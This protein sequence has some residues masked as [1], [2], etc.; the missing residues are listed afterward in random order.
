MQLRLFQSTNTI[1]YEA[2]FTVVFLHPTVIEWPRQSRQMLSVSICFAACQWGRVQSVWWPPIIWG[3]CC[4][5][6]SKKLNLSGP[7]WTRTT[8][9]PQLFHSLENKFRLLPVKWYYIT[10]YIMQMH[11]FIALILFIRYHFFPLNWFPLMSLGWWS[12]LTCYLAKWKW[13]MSVTFWMI[14][15]LHA[16]CAPSNKCS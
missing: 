13:G 16:D 4:V 14:L 5:F 3:P 6:D 11:T 10:F 15:T 9:S 8:H 1:I 7:E 2:L 12:C